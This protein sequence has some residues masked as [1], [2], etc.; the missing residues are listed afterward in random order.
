MV[1]LER[2]MPN[3]IGTFTGT[4]EHILMYLGM[5]SP[6]SGRTAEFLM[7]KALYKLLNYWFSKSNGLPCWDSCCL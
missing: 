5:V 1:G 7:L 4:K 6:E 2:S 3:K